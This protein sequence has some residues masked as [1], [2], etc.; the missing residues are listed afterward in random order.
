MSAEL[1]TCSECSAV[2]AADPARG[3]CGL[4]RGWEHLDPAA[5]PVW[6][7]TTAPQPPADRARVVC[8]ACVG[9][10]PGNALGALATAAPTGAAGCD[11]SEEA[12]RTL[13]PCPEWC[14]EPHDDEC[15]SGAGFHAG[16]VLAQPTVRLWRNDRPGDPAR[17]LVGTAD[18]SPTTAREVAIALLQ[19]AEELDGRGWPQ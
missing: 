5:C 3:G 12:A 16:P 17:I 1:W 15:P 18:V 10:L 11:E 4:P 19:A 9:R 7:Q 8:S 14:I 13:T 2:E 6:V